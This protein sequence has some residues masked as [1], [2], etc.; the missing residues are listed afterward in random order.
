M[1]IT[2]K[3]GMQTSV[4]QLAA[5]SSGNRRRQHGTYAFT[6]TSTSGTIKTDIRL[7]EAVKITP[8]VAM[9]GTNTTALENVCCNDLVTS[10]GLAVNTV[11]LKGLLT[12]SRGGTSITSGLV[13]SVEIDG[14]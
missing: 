3:S 14:Q 4:N 12:I 2:F 9:S 1:A 5:G 8:H 13:F 6:T 10:G 7:V 11:P